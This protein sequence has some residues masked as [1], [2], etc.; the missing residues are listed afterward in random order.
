MILPG[1][2]GTVGNG[3]YIFKEPKL[4][5]DGEGVWE[6]EDSIEHYCEV[7]EHYCA[8]TKA[9][10]KCLAFIAFTISVVSATVSERCTP[11]DRCW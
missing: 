10:N 11:T 6:Q 7:E 8:R 9:F 1:P 2:R 3:A 4:V 5:Y